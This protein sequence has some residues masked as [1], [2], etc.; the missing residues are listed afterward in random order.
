M[1]VEYAPYSNNHLNKMS[2][3]ITSQLIIITN[4]GLEVW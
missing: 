3:P 4:Q 1:L 2:P